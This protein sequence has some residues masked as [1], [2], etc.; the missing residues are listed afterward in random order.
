M[1]RPVTTLLIFFLCFNLFAGILVDT[2]V[3]SDLGVDTTVGTDDAVDNSTQAAQDVATGA[4]TGSTLFG[5]YNV[6][7]GTVS[8]ISDTVTA[9]HIMLAQAGVPTVITDMLN[10]VFGIII[11]IDIL[12]FLRGWGL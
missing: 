2:G 4:P 12:S 10:V 9:G 5:M 6:L 3:A 11:A 1:G 8:A 7:A